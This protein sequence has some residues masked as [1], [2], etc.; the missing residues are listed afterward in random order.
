M[1]FPSDGDLPEV[2]ELEG[3][4]ADWVLWS[5]GQTA[6]TGGL[7]DCGHEGLGPVWHTGDCRALVYLWRERA[8]GSRSGAASRSTSPTPMPDRW[9]GHERLPAPR[10][11]PD[12]GPQ[13][14]R[15]TRPA[16]VVSPDLP[17]VLAAR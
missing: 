12:A 6:D 17:H 10:R 1:S 15:R 7:C 13:P 14:D 16:G 4:G 8:C 9:S 2:V 11:L 3:R 5:H